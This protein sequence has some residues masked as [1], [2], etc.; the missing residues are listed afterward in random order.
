MFQQVLIN[1]L[2][3]SWEDYANVNIIQDFQIYATCGN[4]CFSFETENGKTRKVEETSLKC[5]HEEVDSW[6]S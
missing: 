2:V 5:S 1:F 4:Q 3:A 6:I